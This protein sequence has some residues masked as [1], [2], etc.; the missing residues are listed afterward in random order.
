MK[1]I[2]AEMSEQNDTNGEIKS[3]KG[4]TQ[5]RLNRSDSISGSMHASA[6]SVITPMSLQRR[7][8]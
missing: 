2:L 3:G 5:T 1:K 8:S 4:E 6:P 7:S